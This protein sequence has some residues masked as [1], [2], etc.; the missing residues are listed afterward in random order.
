LLLLLLL[1]LRSLESSDHTSFVGNVWVPKN[2]QIVS[3]ES[4]IYFVTYRSTWKSHRRG[5]STACR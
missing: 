2:R 1:P 3:D 4:S 5:R